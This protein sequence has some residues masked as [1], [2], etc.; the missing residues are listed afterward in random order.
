MA[1]YLAAKADRRTVAA[2]SRTVVEAKGLPAERRGRVAMLVTVSREECRA[3]LCIDE[4]ST[5]HHASH[6]PYRWD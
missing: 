2:M 6:K 4:P 3:A 5:G 1:T